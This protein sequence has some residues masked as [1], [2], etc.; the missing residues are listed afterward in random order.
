MSLVT[1][2]ASLRYFHRLVRIGA[3]TLNASDS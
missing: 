1:V 2:E 3:C